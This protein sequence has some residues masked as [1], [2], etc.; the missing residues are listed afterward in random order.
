MPFLARMDMA[1]SALIHSWMTAPV[2]TR[3]PVWTANFALKRDQLSTI[4][5]F[6]ILKSAGFDSERNCVS[7]T[8]KMEKASSDSGSVGLGVAEVAEVVGGL[9][10][11]SVVELEV[12][13]SM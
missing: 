5:L 2:W 1:S 3:S 6:T 8:Q 11:P 10:V 12:E 13:D 7:V 4:Q 9:V